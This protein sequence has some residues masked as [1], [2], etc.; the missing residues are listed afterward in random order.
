MVFLRWKWCGVQMRGLKTPSIPQ[1]KDRAY[2]LLSRVYDNTDSLTPYSLKTGGLC[3]S[4]V[5]D[6]DTNELCL[7][8]IFEL[9]GWDNYA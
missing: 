7:E 2:E 1:L 6:E 3:A 4:G 8:L 5:Y 9:T